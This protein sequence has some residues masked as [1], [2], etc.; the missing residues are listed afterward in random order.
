M[1]ERAAL[2]MIDNWEVLLGERPLPVREAAALWPRSMGEPAWRAVANI[3]TLLAEARSRHLPVVHTTMLTGAFAARDWYSGT[4]APNAARAFMS[5]G[6][7]AANPFEI[8]ADLAPIAGEVLI[9][10]TG[11]SAFAG[12]PLVSVLQQN[13]VDTLLVCGESTSGC[14]RATVVDAATLGFRTI[15]VEECVYDRHEACHAINLFDMHQK[16]A[17]VLPVED[18]LAWVVKTYPVGTASD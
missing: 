3:K 16:Y 7:A 14:I 11:P 4:R 1:G 15:V 2:L 5:A 17:D 13:R 12:T 10:K 8:M 18:V 9:E 6:T